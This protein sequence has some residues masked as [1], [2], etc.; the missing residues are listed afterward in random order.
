MARIR[1][2][3]G[4]LVV[5]VGV[6]GCVG[7]A[8]PGASPPTTSGTPPPGFDT[9][10]VGEC[11]GTMTEEIYDAVSDTRS[12]VPC[13]EPHGSETFLV[14]ELP[15][16]AAALPRDEV[17]ELPDD[18][19]AKRRVLD[20]CDQEHDRYVGVRR[21]GPDAIRP[22]NLSWAFYLPPPEDWEK[23]ARWVRCDAVTRPF[24]GQ[25]ERTT[26]E[27]LQG[28][29]ASDA[30]PAALRRCYRD[31][32]PPP[33]VNV[34]G[35]GSC[36]QP[37]LGEILV[38]LQVTDPEIDRLADDPEAL[39]DYADPDSFFAT[40]GER[41]APQLGLSAADF[42][43]RTDIKVGTAVLDIA[44]WP[45]DPEARRVWCIAVTERP[46]TGTM[47]GLGTAPLPA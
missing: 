21:L 31:V 41:L 45:T 34:L 1:R 39:A 4:L 15:D 28:V 42:S 46:V 12:T 40:C 7:D 17:A 20:E 16:E 10:Q 3:V 14:T 47:E 22:N 43:R 13:T 33:D 35:L 19:P 38:E 23:G 32:T 18:F 9:P 29:G 27:R 8:D 30:L 24:E 36:D 26:T 44:D 11:R 6:S 5:A 2:T 37:H 25:E